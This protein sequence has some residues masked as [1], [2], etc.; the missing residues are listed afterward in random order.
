[1]NFFGFFMHGGDEIDLAPL[2]DIAFLLLT[3][4]MMTTVFRATDKIQV[5]T[6]QSNSAA[7]E[8]TRRYVIVTVSDSTDKHDTQVVVNMDEYKVRVVAFQGT[9]Y[10]REA[11]GTD[12]VLLKDW[13]KEIY[14][15]LLRARQADPGQTI[16]LKADKNAKFSIV[17]EVMIKM[18]EVKFDQVQMITKMEQ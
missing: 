5:E 14:E 3:F 18:K 16:V 13:R 11:T 10:E 7:K 12:G 4:F 2:V 8:P 17:N 1:M 15:I 9:P 6:P